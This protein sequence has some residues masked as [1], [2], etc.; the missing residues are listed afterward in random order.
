MRCTPTPTR[1]CAERGATSPA[2]TSSACCSTPKSTATQLTQMQL[3][4]FFML[5][6]NAGSRDDAQPHHHRDAG[7]ARA[8]RTSPTAP[9]RP[10]ASPRRDRGAAPVHDAGDAVHPSRR[11]RHRGGR[12]GDRRRRPRAHGLLVGQPR[13][14]RAFNSPDGSTSPASPTTT[15]RSVPAAR[16]SAWRAPGPARGEDHVRGDPHPLRRPGGRGDPATLPRVHSNLIDGLAEMPVRW[17]H[18]R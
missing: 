2:T 8:T 14:A 9:R 11:P 4:V 1:M 16:T 17:D 6:Q 18:V 7:V 13:R 15:S 5:L 3:A 10:L 12:P